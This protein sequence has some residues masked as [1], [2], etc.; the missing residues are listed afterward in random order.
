ML[1][2][3]NNNKREQNVNSKCLFAFKMFFCLS[4]E[5]I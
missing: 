5:N 3:Y 2:N 4:I 1:Q